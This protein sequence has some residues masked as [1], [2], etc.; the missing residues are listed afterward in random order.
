VKDWAEYERIIGRRSAAL[1][2]AKLLAISRWLNPAIRIGSQRT[3]SIAKLHG[4]PGVPCNW[5]HRQHVSKQN[6]CFEVEEL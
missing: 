6:V 1:L 3:A 5:K 2:N 4:F